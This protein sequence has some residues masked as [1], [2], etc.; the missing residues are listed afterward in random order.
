MQ[1]DKL[2][3]FSIVIAVIIVSFSFIQVTD[4][5]FNFLK[6]NQEANS[7]RIYISEINSKEP[8]LGNPEAS[9]FF[10][11]YSDTECPFSTAFAKERER[12]ISLYAETGQIAWVYRPLPL[13]NDA[14][15]KKGLALECVAEEN[16]NHVFWNYLLNIQDKNI[17][18][19]RNNSVS[20][21]MLLEPLKRD[22][23][24]NDNLIECIN[25]ERYTDK[26]TNNI[27]EALDSGAERTPFTV[28]LLSNKI[29][30]S[31]EEKIKNEVVNLPEEILKFLPDTGQIIING[32]IPFENLKNIVDILIAN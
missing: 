27:K 31:K 4:F 14:S 23:I 18:D 24:L 32:K 13:I 25:E 15:F 26:L 7:E 8:V 30:Q 29:S 1:N 12:I 9:I 21:E 10:I 6:K 22:N 16:M 28:I 19:P 5:S 2:I 3:P 11:E 20:V 17:F